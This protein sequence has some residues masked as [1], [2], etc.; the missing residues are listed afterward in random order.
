MIKKVNVETIPIVRIKNDVEHIRINSNDVAGLKT[1]ISDVGLLQPIV[2]RHDGKCYRVIDGHRRLHALMELKIKDLIIGKDVIVV[3]NEKD[4]DNFFKQL[5]ANI[6]REDLNDI[7]LGRAFVLLKEKGKYQFN[8]I[9]DIIQKTPHYVAAKVGLAKRL[10]P[11]LQDLTMKDWETA[12]CICNTFTSQER[13]DP[14]AD[15]EQPY[16]ININVIE[17]VARLPVMLQMAVY[18]TIKEKE[19]ENSEALSY[20]RQVKKGSETLVMA[21]DVKSTLESYPGEDKKEKLP[22][23]VIRGYVKKIGTNLDRL[24]ISVMEMEVTERDKILPELESLM[25]RLS[26]L[27]SDLKNKDQIEAEKS[28]SAA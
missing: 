11:E 9:A 26:Q 24:E 22:G 13:K 17:D 25:E 15:I 5:I 21:D 23:K 4:S 8:D 3:E 6:Q 2:V 14:E 28:K 12:K 16:S 20:I 1:T 18:Q 7:E 10:S 19:M 27:Y